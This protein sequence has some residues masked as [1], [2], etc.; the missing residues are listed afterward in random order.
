MLASLP[1]GR[2]AQAKNPGPHNTDPSFE[3]FERVHRFLVPSAILAH[4]V[5]SAWNRKRIELGNRAGCS[6]FS[7]TLHVS[8][9]LV[10]FQVIRLKTFHFDPQFGYDLKLF[11]KFLKSMKHQQ[12]RDS[13]IDR[14]YL[15][16]LCVTLT[17]PIPLTGYDG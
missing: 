10:Q 16:K 17:K 15:L 2:S 1:V 8:Y 3:C 12:Q 5:D 9:F 4:V 11:T 6:L 14:T 7:V 13:C